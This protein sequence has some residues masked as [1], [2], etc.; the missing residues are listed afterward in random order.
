LTTVNNAADGMHHR[1]ELITTTA[2]P[3]RSEHELAAE[4]D[5]FGTVLAFVSATW[6]YDTGMFNTVL[7]TWAKQVVN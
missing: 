7:A 1:N 2:I 4:G 3:Y 5:A 6:M